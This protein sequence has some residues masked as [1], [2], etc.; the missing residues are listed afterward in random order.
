MFKTQGKTL[1]IGQD[2]PV[3]SLESGLACREAC[4]RT[5]FTQFGVFME[6]YEKKLGD[7]PRHIDVICYHMYSNMSS[8]GLALRSA[9]QLHRLCAECNQYVVWVAFTAEPE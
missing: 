2:S 8:F 9:L 4:T 1:V 6:L 3:H 5:R 7:S